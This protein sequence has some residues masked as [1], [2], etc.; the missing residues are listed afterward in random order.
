MAAAITDISA[1]ERTATVYGDVRAVVK[2]LRLSGTDDIAVVLV[3]AGG[4]IM[5]QDTGAYR[6]AAFS[7][8]QSRVRGHS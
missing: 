2:G 1:R 4:E 8:L 5:W 6:E 7:E 3:R